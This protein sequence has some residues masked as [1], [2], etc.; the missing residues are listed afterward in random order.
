VDQV[1]PVFSRIHHLQIYFGVEDIGQHQPG[2]TGI[3]TDNYF[4]LFDNGPF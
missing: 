1:L 3:V 4:D 2:K